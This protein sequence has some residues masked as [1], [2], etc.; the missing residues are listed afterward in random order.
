MPKDQRDES[1]TIQRPLLITIV[2]IFGFIGFA[3]MFVALLIPSIR[4]LL[5]QRHGILF[6][7]LS[8]L[9]LIFGVAG[10]IGYWKM[11]RWGIYLYFIM[12]IISFGSGFLLNIRTKLLDYVLPLVIIGIGLVYF[13]R[14]K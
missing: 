13:K 14:M 7:F 3:T 1:K 6:I 5:V 9:T 11:N 8:A 12:A 10:L 4:N 2:C